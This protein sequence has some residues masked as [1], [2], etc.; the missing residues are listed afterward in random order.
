MKEGS[1]F[2]KMLFVSYFIKFTCLS[3]GKYV[4]SN[5]QELDTIFGAIHMS[6]PLDLI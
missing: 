4:T 3:K 1:Q 6:V 2:T 5:L